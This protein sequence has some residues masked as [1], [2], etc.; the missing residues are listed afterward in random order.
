MIDDDSNAALPGDEGAGL[1]DEPFAGRDGALAAEVLTS[2]LTPSELPRGGWERLHASLA[3]TDEVGRSG[4]RSVRVEATRAAPPHPPPPRRSLAWAAAL[5]AAVLALGAVGAWGVTQRNEAA[6]LR[7]DQRILA[8]WMAN[9]GMRLTP[10]EP[11]EGVAAV[12]L[13]V[14]CVLP[15]GRALV[16]QPTRPEGGATYVVVGWGDSGLRELARGRD[17]ML[18]FDATGVQVVELRTERA[19]QTATLAV[20]RLN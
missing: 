2:A 1:A 19:G 7:D 4:P 5:V 3:A 8:Y 9:P 18:Q 6:R 12:R 17:N 15:D 11:A 10:L 14:L 20:A 13:G 16:L